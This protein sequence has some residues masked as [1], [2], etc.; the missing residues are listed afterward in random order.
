MRAMEAIPDDQSPGIYSQ[1]RCQII[2][3]TRQMSL[4]NPKI[5][6]GWK[7]AVERVNLFARIMEIT[8]GLEIQA[9][10][11][12][13]VWSRCETVGLSRA[14]L[15]DAFIFAQPG[16]AKDRDGALSGT[17]KK[18]ATPTPLPALAAVPCKPSVA[19]DPIAAAGPV[20][21]P[22]VPSPAPVADAP[23][24]ASAE[25]VSSPT[26]AGEKAPGEK[27][28]K[29]TVKSAKSSQTGKTEKTDR[30]PV[31]PPAQASLF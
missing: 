18:T 6:G 5:S 4:D 20:P 12:D 23:A 24:P 9:G 28:P 1:I 8:G 25:P 11:R 13:T 7:A 2:D 31:T 19:V 30:K 27:A 3:I 22:A 10:A 14:D 26:T 15:V 16:M 17:T 21:Q 29:K